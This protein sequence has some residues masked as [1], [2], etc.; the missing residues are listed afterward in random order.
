[1]T[2]RRAYVDTR[3]GQVHYRAAG[4]GP[5][6]VLLHQTA[7]SSV[8][9]EPIMARL[10]HRHR[11]IAPDTPGFGGSDPL[12]GPASVARY[13]EVLAEAL[14]R[15]EIPR[16]DL[17]GHHSGASIAVQIATDH[18]QQ[19]ARLALSGPPYLTRAQLERLIPAVTP[20]VLDESGAQFAAAWQR[21]R[22]KDRTAPLALAQ[23]EAV[24]T[25]G[26]GEHYPA[27]YH[28]VFAHDFAGQL[29]RLAQATLVMAGPDDT[30]FDSLEPA[31]RALQRGTRRV[32][33]RGGTYVCDREPDLVVEALQSFFKEEPA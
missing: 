30:I 33:A 12:A 23:R 15:L 16:Y 3:F 27:A 11:L 5:P 13:A 20:V 19:V 21:V 25:L 32:L 1:M 10:E 4:S 24:L 7:S 8:M 2:I 17:F 9:F 18:P 29:A 6:L 14:Q 28:A 22:N 26:A 31:F